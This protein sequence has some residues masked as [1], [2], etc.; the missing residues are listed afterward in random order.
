MSRF[1]RSCCLFDVL[2]GI[3]RFRV[4]CPVS[5]ARF[6]YLMSCLV[7]LALVLD[8]SVPYPDAPYHF[9]ISRNGLDDK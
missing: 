8:V 7:L 1:L 6:A 9:N 2:C 4:R 5:H 3:A